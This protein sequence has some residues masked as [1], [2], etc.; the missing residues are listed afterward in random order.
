MKPF[1]LERARAGD[2]V[3]DTLLREIVY[4]VGVEAYGR[5]IVQRGNQLFIRN[6][7]DLV[8]VPKKRTVWVNLYPVSIT[9]DTEEEAD[10]A[11]V[12][13]FKRLGGKAYPVEIE[14]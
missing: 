3:Y 7:Y 9:Y 6:K 8:M 13:D 1:D 12:Y 10:A 2:Q 14:E 11:Q 5:F 4:F